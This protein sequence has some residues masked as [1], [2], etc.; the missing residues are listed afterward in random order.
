MPAQ[1]R[2]R[3]DQTR[4]AQ[5]ARQVGDSHCEQRSI[6]RP[7]LRPHDLAAQNIDLVPQHQQLDALQVQPTATPNEPAKQS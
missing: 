3:S 2:P 7:E 6:S 5:P 4:A 1:Q